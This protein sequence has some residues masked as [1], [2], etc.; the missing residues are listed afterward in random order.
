MSNSCNY[1]DEW[2]AYNGYDKYEYDVKLKDGTVVENCYPKCGEFNSFSDLHDGQRFDEGDVMEIRFSQNPIFYINDEVSNVTP[3]EEYIRRVEISR[4]RRINRFSSMA[5]IAAV[6]GDAVM[7]ANQSVYEFAY[8]PNH[9]QG[10]AIKK[11]R[12]VVVDVRTEPKI[13]RNEICPKCDSG[14]KYKR[15]CGKD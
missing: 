5:I 4:Q 13:G 2:Q 8:V 10:F 7:N 6:M 1:S 9:S 11:Q 14:I 3:D 12:G 15:C